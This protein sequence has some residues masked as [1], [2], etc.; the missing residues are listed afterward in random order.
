MANYNAYIRT[1]YFHV[2]DPVAFQEYMKGVCADGTIDVWEGEKENRGTFAFGC[3]GP[4]FGLP[5]DPEDEDAGFDYDA[6]IAG[7]SEHVAEDDAIII[8]EAGHEKLRYVVGFANIITG[9][10][11]RCVCLTNVAEGIAR[12]MLDNP[13][14]ATATEY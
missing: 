5:C 14:W 1:N 13:D 7:L 8:L 12:E 2:K 10:G 4:I 3:E 6:F 11:S 9:K